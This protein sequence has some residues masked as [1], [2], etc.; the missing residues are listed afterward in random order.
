M[1]HKL[2]GAAGPSQHSELPRLQEC[3]QQF[4]R[5]GQQLLELEFRASLSTGRVGSRFL[6]RMNFYYSAFYPQ[7]VYATICCWCT[8]SGYSVA[9]TQAAHFVQAQLQPL[10]WALHPNPQRYL[11][12][13]LSKRQIPSPS[14]PLKVFSTF[15]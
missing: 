7:P 15:V 8:N 14:F 12:L 2:W 1:S 10:L 5:I 4:G 13:W 3:Q 9:L 6:S 11:I